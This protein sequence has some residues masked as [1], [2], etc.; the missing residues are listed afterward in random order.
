MT[1][2]SQGEKSVRG[3]DRALLLKIFLSAVLVGVVGC[4]GGGGGD[5]EDNGSDSSDEP[6]VSGDVD[7]GAD[8]SGLATRCGTI[9]DRKLLNPVSNDRG[10]QVQLVAVLDSNAVIVTNGS[11][12][13]LV[14]LQG[15]GGTTGFQNTAAASLFTEL[16]AAP[17]FL[18]RAGGC[19][20]TVIGGQTGTVGSI[21][22]ST[23]TSFTEELIAKKYAGVIETSGACG[24]ESLAACFQSISASNEHHVY[25]APKQ[26]TTMP[27]SVRYRPSDT[28]CGGNASIVVDNEQF[29]SVFSIQLRYPDGTDRIID[30]CESAGCTPLKVQGYIRTDSLT[31]GCFGA[32]GNAVAL[33]DINHVSIKR[34]GDD[35]DPP[36]YCIADPSVAIN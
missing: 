1:F 3:L 11:E 12:Q 26:C 29:G 15:V 25:G 4:G 32:P 8:D 35:S 13:V 20:G 6:I 31:V 5:D 34:E 18:F 28:D 22:T 16:A 9:T 2:F 7:S 19:T 21:I 17:L 36:R 23:G 14:K 27:T 30:E 24:E 10:E 33:S